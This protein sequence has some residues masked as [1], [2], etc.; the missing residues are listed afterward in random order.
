MMLN[1]LGTLKKSWEKFNIM[2]MQAFLRYKKSQLAMYP[3]VN[4]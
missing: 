3:D 2:K 1:A 4:K